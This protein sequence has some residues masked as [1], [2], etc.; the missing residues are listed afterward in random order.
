MCNMSVIEF[1]MRHATIDDF[2]GKRV[3][4]VGSK[5]ID[6]SVRPLIE[7][8]CHPREYVGI[9]IEPGEFVDIVMPCENI[10]GCFGSESFDV[11]ISTET[12]EH[13]K[14][15]R[16]V[17]NNMKTVLKPQGLLYLTT[18]SKG[19]AYH[20]Y[21]NDYWRYEISDLE[22]I[23]NDFKIIKLKKNSETNGIFIK[24]LKPENWKA[25]DCSSIDLYS[26]IIGKRSCTIMNMKDVSF[27]RKVKI[28]NIAK[29]HRFVKTNLPKLYHY[30]LSQ[31]L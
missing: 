12:I 27:L 18:V 20:G 21:P 26:I 11:V 5:Y 25:A 22:K 9:D 14:D 4:E 23:F 30:L 2:S 15:W 6:G 10:L 24:A 3:L 16:L 7:R 28:N 19:Y 17:I 29:I 13:L 8:F 1:F 31:L